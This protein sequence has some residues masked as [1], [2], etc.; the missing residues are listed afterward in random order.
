MII[1]SKGKSLAIM[2]ER[3]YTKSLLLLQMADQN[4]NSTLV[5]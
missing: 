5:F 2:P 3:A 4:E 1:T